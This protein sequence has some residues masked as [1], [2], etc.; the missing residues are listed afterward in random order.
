MQISNFPHFMLKLH[1]PPPFKSS[2]RPPTLPESSLS[3]CLMKGSVGCNTALLSCG[4][5]CM[6]TKGQQYL[7]SKLVFVVFLYLPFYFPPYQSILKC[8][9]FEELYLGM[10][11]LVCRYIPNTKLLHIICVWMYVH[12]YVL[13]AWTLKAFELWTPK[14]NE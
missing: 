4:K 9:E 3:I 14:I 1:L 5:G 7:A 12:T 11:L 8:F 6:Y 2:T 13:S 10:P